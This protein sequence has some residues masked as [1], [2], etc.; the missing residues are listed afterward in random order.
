MFLKDAHD[1]QKANPWASCV[2]VEILRQKI[3]DVE[4]I[5]ICIFLVLLNLVKETIW[6]HFRRK[7][8]RHFSTLTSPRDWK[9]RGHT[10]WGHCFRVRTSSPLVRDLSSYSG[11]VPC[12]CVV[13]RQQ[14]ESRLVA[15]TRF[16]QLAT[17][18]TQIQ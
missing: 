6:W 7:L 4:N 2:E 15:H 18:A 9:L 17:L 3:N 1:K 11:Y 10:D 14:A 5:I 8:Y 13:F 16:I 12:R